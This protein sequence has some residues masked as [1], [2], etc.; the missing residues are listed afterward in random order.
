MHLTRRVT[1]VD[2]PEQLE[3]SHVGRGESFLI[4]L[5]AGSLWVTAVCE[6]VGAPAQHR[7]GQHQNQSCISSHL[8][9]L[10]TKAV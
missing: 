3:I 9:D 7:D 4:L 8:H 10:S 2:L 1:C 6:P 5:P